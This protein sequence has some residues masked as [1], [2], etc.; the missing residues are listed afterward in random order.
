MDAT[1]KLNELYERY[2]SVVEGSFH[3]VL[4]QTM[5]NKTLDPINSAFTPKRYPETFE[6][7]LEEG[8]E[9]IIAQA[10]GGYIP[11]NIAYTGDAFDE[12]LTDL[13]REVFG[14]TEDD[15]FNIECASHQ[16]RA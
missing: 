9:V 14:H 10:V 16:A 12:F 1:D 3:N 2:Q 5:I 13:N 8:K 4:W 11:A 7:T 15:A 6:E